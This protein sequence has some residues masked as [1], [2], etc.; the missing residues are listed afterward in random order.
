MPVLL[1][2]LAASSLPPPA[3]PTAFDPESFCRNFTVGNER[4]REFYS[5]GYPG[6]YPPSSV[7]TR[8]LTAPHGHFL[9]VISLLFKKIK[10]FGFF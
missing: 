10:K 9:Q 2:L 8:V 3:S 1:L 6:H 7:C 4:E 5:P